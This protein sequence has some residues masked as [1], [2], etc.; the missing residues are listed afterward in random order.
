MAAKKKMNAHWETFYDTCHPCHINYDFI[1][2]MESLEQDNECFQHK[3]LNQTK[4]FFAYKPSAI[5]AQLVRNTEEL[6]RSYYR[7]ITDVK[8]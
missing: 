7:N 3:I 5:K 4:T 1:G 2:K 8:M 6:I